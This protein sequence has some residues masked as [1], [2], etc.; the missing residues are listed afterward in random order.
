MSDKL[1]GKDEFVLKSDHLYFKYI[2]LK[3]RKRYYNPNLKW[4]K[5]YLS[6]NVKSYVIEC[7]IDETDLIMLLINIPKDV[8]EIDECLGFNKNNNNYIEDDNY[9]EYFE[10]S[11]AEKETKIYKEGQFIGDLIIPY[12][13]IK[14]N[15]FSIN[16]IIYGINQDKIDNK[17]DWLDYK[18]KGKNIEILFNLSVY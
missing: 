14:D 3:Y 1:W 2:P 12:Q 4:N 7:I 9:I 6:T 13:G 17:K 16:F 8:Y 18:E 10:N 11:K 15:C 5:T